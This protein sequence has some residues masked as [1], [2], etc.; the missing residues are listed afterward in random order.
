MILW[1]QHGVFGGVVGFLAVNMCLIPHR[2]EKILGWLAE[3]NVLVISN[4]TTSIRIP[5][6]GITPSGIAPSG[7]PSRRGIPESGIIFSD[8]VAC[9]G[10][11][12][13]AIEPLWL[14][15]MYC[16]AC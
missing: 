14:S 9:Y 3:S 10:I 11:T 8:R 6:S 13:S 1:R 15:P 12:S 5:S 4:E 2:H 7:T 16:A